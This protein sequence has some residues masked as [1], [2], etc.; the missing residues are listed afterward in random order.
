MKVVIFVLVTIVTLIAVSLATEAAETIYGPDGRVVARS[1]TDSSGSTT[2]YDA[3]G[4]VVGRSAYS[5]ST[6]TTTFYDA[7]GRVVGTAVKR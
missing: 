7:S 6:G 5:A 2:T 4:R 3:S 1:T